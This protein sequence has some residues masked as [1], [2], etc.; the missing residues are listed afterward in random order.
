MQCSVLFALLTATLLFAL[1]CK[2]REEEAVFTVA[3]LARLLA[4]GSVGVADPV[5]RTAPFRIMRAIT[6]F[7][8]TDWIL[9]PG[10]TLIGT[11]A[12]L[13]SSILSQSRV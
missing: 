9:P 13:S 12:S 11:R 1:L 8:T 2:L 7:A 5:F 10:T 6:V 3:G 4:M